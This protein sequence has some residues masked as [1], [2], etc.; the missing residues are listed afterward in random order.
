MIM[1]DLN[2]RI[3]DYQGARMGPSAYDV[4]S[5]LWDPYHRLED[6]MR[7]RLTD[8][9]ISKI[10]DKF[11]VDYFRET[12]AVCR[13]QRHMQALGAYGYLSFVKGKRYFLKY[14]PEGLRLLKEDVELFRN[15]YPALYELVTML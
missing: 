7:E 6:R 12:L 2:L 1:A 10:E 3:I 9:Y 13:L 14:V 8:Y 15:E 4:A 5:L 11:D